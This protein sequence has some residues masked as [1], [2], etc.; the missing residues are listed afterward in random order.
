MDRNRRASRTSAATGP[1]G[2]RAWTAIQSV[3]DRDPSSP[4]TCRASNAAV[5]SANTAANRACSRRNDSIA[6][7]NSTSDT[8]SGST[9]SSPSI[10]RAR[11]AT[12]ASKDAVADA[13]SDPTDSNTSSH[14]SPLRH[15]LPWKTSDSHGFRS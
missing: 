2:S 8:P 15:R 5:C 13:R 3:A 1:R 6:S 11:L 9:S 14:F 12:S 4:Y 7:A 10:A